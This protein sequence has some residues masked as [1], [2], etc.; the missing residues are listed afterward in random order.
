MFSSVHDVSPSETNLKS[1]WDNSPTFTSMLFNQSLVNFQAYIYFLKLC[2]F[3][4]K[5]IFL[6][7][8]PVINYYFHKSICFM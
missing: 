5:K 1:R 7:S 8:L 3:K 4:H 2:V 6:S